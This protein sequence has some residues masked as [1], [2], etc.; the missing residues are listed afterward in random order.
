[1]RAVAVTG[2]GLAIGLA[3]ASPANARPSDPG[4]V[5]YAVLGKGSV[6]NIVGAPMRASPR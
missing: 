5:N 1:M 6:G 3:L 2:V 4:V